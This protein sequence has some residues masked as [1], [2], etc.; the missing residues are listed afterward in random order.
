MEKVEDLIYLG[1]ENGVCVGVNEDFV[2]KLLIVRFT[3]GKKVREM[4]KV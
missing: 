2:C 1:L 3:F 4:T